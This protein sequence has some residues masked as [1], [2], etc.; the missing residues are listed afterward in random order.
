MRTDMSHYFRSAVLAAGALIWS[1]G[2]TLVAQAPG[3]PGTPGTTK[4]T[5]DGIYT[6]EQSTR[7]EAV[8]KGKCSSC[9]GDDLTGGGFAPALAGDAFFEQWSEKKLSELSS[10]IKD[11]MPADK[12]GSLTP[13]ETADVLAYVLK[14]NGLPA[15][16]APL[17]NDAAALAQVAIAKP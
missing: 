17:S 2:V 5:K 7:G 8:Y 6:A 9:H 12:P 1:I 3:T 15:G 10:E 4:T 14:S 13:D 16:A 11:S